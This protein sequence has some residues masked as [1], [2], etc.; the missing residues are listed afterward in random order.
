MFR[1][2]ASATWISARRRRIER[3]GQGCGSP[4]TSS[5]TKA[6]CASHYPRVVEVRASLPSDKSFAS[7]EEALAHV[8]GP[9]LPDNTELYWNQGLLDVLFEYPIRSDSSEFSIHPKLERLGLRTV[10]VLRFL[11]PGGA[12][13]AFEFHGDPG[14][15]RLDPRWHQAALR[16]V[17]AGFF[18]ILDGTDHL[19][20]LLCL[21]IPFRRFRALVL[22]VTAFTVAHSIT[23]IASAYDLG[24][25]CAVVPAAHRN[26]DRHLHRLHGAREHR[27]RQQ[28]AAAAG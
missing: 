3:R 20:F 16:F 1:A 7:Y 8:T 25:D 26:A 22:I 12:V 11:P 5:C 19:L 27:R 9:R 15:V 18:H 24:P 21:V 17:E 28:R 4:T 10:T 23:L 2:V 6:R 14:L 13:R